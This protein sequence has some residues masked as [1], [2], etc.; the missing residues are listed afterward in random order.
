MLM[1]PPLPLLK[2]NRR[3][4]RLTDAGKNDGPQAAVSGRPPQVWGPGGGALRGWA[5]P[6]GGAMGRGVCGMDLALG[7]SEGRYATPPSSKSFGVSKSRNFF[8]S[9][10]SSLFRQHYLSAPPRRPTRA[11]PAAGDYGRRE[12]QIMIK[13]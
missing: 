4:R 1:Q 13:Q 12:Q 6:Q 11:T 7:E 5:A 3:F 10:T 9:P 2:P 8:R